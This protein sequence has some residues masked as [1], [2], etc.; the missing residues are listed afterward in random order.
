MRKC[1]NSFFHVI[2]RLFELVG[3]RV[4]RWISLQVRHKQE[5]ESDSIT[6]DQRAL[7]RFQR[8]FFHQSLLSS[9]NH[10]MPTKY[11]SERNWDYSKLLQSTAHF[12]SIWDQLK[13]SLSALD[14]LRTT[15]VCCTS[16]L[17]WISMVSMWL[18]SSHYGR[19][20][21]IFNDD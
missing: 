20:L 8:I 4:R 12:S 2:Q 17:W 14:Q 3:W 9:E 19:P 11:T 15:R 5:I 21:F 18:T 10:L 7:S 16:L 13:V 6:Y 1:F